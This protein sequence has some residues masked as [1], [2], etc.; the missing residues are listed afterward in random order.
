LGIFTSN[1]QGG[2]LK[3][4]ILTLYKKSKLAISF[5]NYGVIS[6]LRLDIISRHSKTINAE[7]KNG[8]PGK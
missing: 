2:R 6:C 5:R 3:F 7:T 4:Y 8:I 1:E